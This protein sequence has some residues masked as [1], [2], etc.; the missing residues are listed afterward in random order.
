MNMRYIGHVNI[1][2]LSTFIKYQTETSTTFI[3]GLMHE[4]AGG[5]IR[6]TIQYTR[7]KTL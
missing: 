5:A 6:T 3:Y 4:V 2:W 1:S 7:Q